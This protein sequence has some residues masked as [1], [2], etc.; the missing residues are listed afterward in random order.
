MTNPKIQRE[1]CGPENGSHSHSETI[2]KYEVREWT[3]VNGGTS[4][5][6]IIM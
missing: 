1:T 3:A 6:F 4:V 5:S 2:V